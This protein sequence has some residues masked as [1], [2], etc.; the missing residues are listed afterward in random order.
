MVGFHLATMQMPRHCLKP[1]GGH[2]VPDTDN[3][4]ALRAFKQGERIMQRAAGLWAVLPCYQH[5]WEAAICSLSPKTQDRR[6]GA[7]REVGRV[8]Q[9]AGVSLGRTGDQQVGGQEMVA[10]RFGRFI[11][12]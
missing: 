11:D 3:C 12:A 5:I 7:K 10:H 8:G 1:V 9:D 2:L 4:Y 6:A